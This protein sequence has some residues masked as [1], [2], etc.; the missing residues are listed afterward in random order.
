MMFE[1]PHF[2]FYDSWQKNAREF[3]RRGTEGCRDKGGKERSDKVTKCE[4]ARMKDGEERNQE[5]T[6]EQQKGKKKK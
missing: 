3:K 6:T 4:K 2:I 5:K 1:L